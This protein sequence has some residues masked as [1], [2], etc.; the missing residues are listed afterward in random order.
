MLKLKNPGNVVFMQEWSPKVL[1]GYIA[2]FDAI[3][4]DDTY[5]GNI[6]LRI[7]NITKKPQWLSIKWFK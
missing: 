1:K 5:N 4:Y 7:I 2:I 6:A 3:K